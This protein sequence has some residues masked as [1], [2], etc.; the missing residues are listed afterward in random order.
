MLV[1][2]THYA[3]GVVSR[4]VARSILA[5]AAACFVPV[6]SLAQPAAMVVAP[7]PAPAHSPSPPSTY[8]YPAYPVP[9]W[10]HPNSVRCEQ[11]RLLTD[12]TPCGPATERSNPLP[13]C[14]QDRPLADRTPCTKP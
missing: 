3:R 7:S 14:Q 10:V 4:G 1:G 11:D 6:A 12:T 13:P 8:P 2:L 9:D 5:G